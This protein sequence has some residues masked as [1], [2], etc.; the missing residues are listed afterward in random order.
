M[1]MVS[2]RVEDQEWVRMDAKPFCLCLHYYQN[3]PLLL[4][5]YYTKPVVKNAAARLPLTPGGQVG[6][7]GDGEWEECLCLCHHPHTHT[8]HTHT[9][10]FR[11]EGSEKNVVRG[12]L[13]NQQWWA[14]N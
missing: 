1:K 2:N 7:G 6:V 10:T 12:I 14:Y 8:T 4:L 9:Q 11:C 3:M 13:D 5:L